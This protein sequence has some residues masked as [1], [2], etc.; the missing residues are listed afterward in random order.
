MKTIKNIITLFLTSVVIVACNSKSDL[1]NQEYYNKN[2]IVSKFIKDVKSLES[3]T[4]TNPIVAFK[5]LAEE[6]ADNKIIVSKN[7]KP[8]T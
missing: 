2:N 1:K 3:D 4:N 7:F 5:Q 6:I 8:N